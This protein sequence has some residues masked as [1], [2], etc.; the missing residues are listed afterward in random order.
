MLYLLSEI[1]LPNYGSNAVQATTI[2]LK[3]LDM[4]VGALK[5]KLFKI[6]DAKRS[7]GDRSLHP[8]GPDY[9]AFKMTGE[10][11]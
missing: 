7:G 4:T 3:P 6:C 1:N 8:R 2:L 5:E 11:G 9:C 10:R